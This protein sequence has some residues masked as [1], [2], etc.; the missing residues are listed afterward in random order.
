L[1]TISGK[2][3]V[4]LLEEN[5]WQVVRLKGSHH[6]LQH[7]DYEE[8]IIVPVHGNKDIK[9]GLL[10]KIIKTANIDINKV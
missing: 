8:S 5:G 9:I 1:K 10:N 6:I 3:L 2:K 7:F 4:K